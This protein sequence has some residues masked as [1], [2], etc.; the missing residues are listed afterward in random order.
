VSSFKTNPQNILDEL[1]KVHGKRAKAFPPRVKKGGLR[2]WMMQIPAGEYWIGSRVSEYNREQPRHKVLVEKSYYLGQVPVTVGLW[3]AVDLGNLQAFEF[4][5]PESWLPKVEISWED[6]M[7]NPKQEGWLQKFTDLVPPPFD[8]YWHLPNEAEWEAG[9]R[10]ATLS[11]YWNGQDEAALAAV[12][13]YG[14]NSEN[15]LR[16]VLE[17]PSEEAKEHPFGL[18]HLHGLV[19]EWCEDPWED[20]AYISK[21]PNDINVATSK[22]ETPNRVVRG[23]SW[24]FSAEWCRSSFRYFGH[25]DVG[26]DFRGF[27]LCLSPRPPHAS[28]L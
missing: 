28:K 25:P 1:A 21:T 17:F 22:Q 5:D 8:L 6:V 11:E 15:R 10:A 20:N 14:E 23:G 4:G 26:G 24:R 27:R 3:K 7:G 9:C 19:W 16:L 12:G 2:F 13:W 18:L